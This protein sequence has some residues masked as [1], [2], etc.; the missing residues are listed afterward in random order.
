MGAV[1]YFT[2]REACRLQG[3]P[4]TFIPAG[5]SSQALRQLGNAMPAQLAKVAGHWIRQ[6]MSPR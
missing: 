5:S 1:R 3:M 2:V 4:D 6:C